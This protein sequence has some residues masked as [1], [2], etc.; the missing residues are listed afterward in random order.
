M[1]ATSVGVTLQVANR[2]CETI[3]HDPFPIGNEG[4]RVTVTLSVG[5][6]HAHGEDDTPEA[7]IQR[8]DAALYKANYLGRNRVNC[9][10]LG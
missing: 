3:S 5:I 4:V 2:L 10:P 8:A 1:P 7:I 6:S 9:P